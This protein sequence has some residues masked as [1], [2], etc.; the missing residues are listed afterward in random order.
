VN[1]RRI[2]RADLLG[3]IERLREVCTEAERAGHQ[4]MALLAGGIAYEYNLLLN[5]IQGSAHLALL[6]LDP[7]SPVRPML[8]EIERCGERAAELT[9]QLLAF[10]GKERIPLRAV[11]LAELLREAARRV[12]PPLGQPP[13]E[14]GPARRPPERPE[15]QRR[16]VLVVDDE[17]AVLRV[18]QRILERDGFEVRTAASGEEAIIA[19]RECPERI[20]VVLLDVVMPKMDGKATFDEL[21]RIRSDLPVVFMSGHGEHEIATRLIED[22][23]A[24]FL[25]KPFSLEGLREKISGEL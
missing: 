13:T 15:P 10:A 1:A 8:E 25:H 6:K 12:P 4:R 24:D 3:E 11:D 7:G 19:L 23:Q 22:T 18:A 16:S 21:R 2:S 5:G 14:E 20:D 9:R 17:Q